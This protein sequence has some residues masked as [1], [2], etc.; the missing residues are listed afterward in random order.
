[1][2][3]NYCGYVDFDGIRYFDLREKDKFWFPFEQEDPQIVLKSDA[4]VRSDL[5]FL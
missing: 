1:M 2:N 3:G 4:T 5:L